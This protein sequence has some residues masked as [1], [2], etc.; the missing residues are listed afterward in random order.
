M[1]PELFTIFGITVQSYG[2]SKALAILVAGL[3]LARAFRRHNLSGDAAWS[4]VIH[5]TIWGF[6]GAKLYFLAEHANAFSWHHLGGMGFTWY[7]GMIGGTIA[8]LMVIRRQQPPL[9]LVSGLVPYATFVLSRP[10]RRSRR[11]LVT[12]LTEENAMAA[13]AMIGLS[14]PSAASGMAA[15]L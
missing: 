1:L 14:S 15:V 4:L 8:A 9:G 2:I 5:T 11:E 6:V 7:G 13:P 10:K 3:V 12:T